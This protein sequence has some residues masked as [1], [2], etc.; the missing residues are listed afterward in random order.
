MRMNAV[1]CQIF[2]NSHDLASSVH[3]EGEREKGRN[4]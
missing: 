3:P 1:P 4:N 2:E